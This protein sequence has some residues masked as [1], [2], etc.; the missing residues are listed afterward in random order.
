MDGEVD[1]P[2]LVAVEITFNLTGQAL[3]TAPFSGRLRAD[4][5][6]RDLA[7]QSQNARD[8]GINTNLAFT[9]PAGRMVQGYDAVGDRARD[10]KYS[11]ADR[12]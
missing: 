3:D 4:I 9:G 7:L 11:G 8:A 12:G 2:A 1:K 6:N 10:R 5:Q